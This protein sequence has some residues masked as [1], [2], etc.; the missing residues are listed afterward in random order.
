MTEISAAL[1]KQLRELTGAGVMDAK[2]ALVESRGALEPARE[3]LRRK[4]MADAT[5]RSGRTVREGL[6]DAYLHPGGRVG[7][8]LEVNCE[9]DFVARTEP[10]RA[11]V[12]DLALQIAAH[13]PEYV[14]REQVPAAIVEREQRISR[15]QAEDQGKSAQIAER[16]T[17]GKMEAFYQQV[18]LYD[19]PWIRDEGNRRRKVEEVV[20]EVASTLGEHL[21]V[22]RFTRYTLGESAGDGGPEP[23]GDPGGTGGAVRA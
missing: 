8:L 11:L 16:M 21:D 14:R 22:A 9:T 1:V 20:R 10:F 2:R 18:C 4:G 12:H 15:G 5:K 13:S 17:T 3:I 19:Q 7:V 6:V 23:K